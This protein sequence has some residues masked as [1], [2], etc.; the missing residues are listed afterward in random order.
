M[1]DETAV[2]LKELAEIMN[3]KAILTVRSDRL[4]YA[5]NQS[6]MIGRS[7]LAVLRPDQPETVAC[8]LRPTPAA[9]VCC[10]TV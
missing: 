10:N 4:G 9:A 3:E 7:P 8:V 2:I 6:G 1:Q 5:S